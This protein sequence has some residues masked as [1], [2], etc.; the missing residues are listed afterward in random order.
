MT[1]NPTNCSENVPARGLGKLL[2]GLPQIKGCAGKPVV[3]LN[4]KAYCK[5]PSLR[6]EQYLA[7]KGDPANVTWLVERETPEA[8][9]Q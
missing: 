7:A 2:S 6:A 5:R 4:G 9:Q 1:I 3:V 8:E